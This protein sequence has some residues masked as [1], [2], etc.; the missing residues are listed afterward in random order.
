M[1]KKNYIWDLV[2]ISLYLFLNIAC[3]YLITNEIVIPKLFIF[4]KESFMVFNSI[5]GELSYLLMLLG[6]AYILFKTRR[7]RFIFLTIVSFVYSLFAFAMSV[8]VNYYG[9]LFSFG[10]LENFGSE[11]ASKSM[12]FLLESIPTVI[13]GSVPGFFISFLI[14]ILFYIIYRVKCFKK[15]K[16][17]VSKKRKTLLGTIIILC[18]LLLVITS[19][20]MYSSK[21][22]G[23]WFEYNSSP[24]YSS[25]AKGLINTY[26]D[27]G[28]KELFNNDKQLSL[29]DENKALN[30]LQNYQ[31]SNRINFYDNKSY[32][33]NLEFSGIF[34]DKNLLLIQMES[35]S[36]F[37]IGLK[38]NVDGTFREVTPN[39]NQMVRENIYFSSYYTT[40][41]IG[42][43]SDSEFSILTGMY[44]I[45]DVFSIFSCKSDY[46]QTLPR[47]FK[48][49]GYDTF[50]SHANSRSFYDRGENH[51][52]MY[53]FDKFYG[54]EDLDIDEDEM[55]RKWLS[56]EAF[57]KQ[58]I[59]ILA[60]SSNNS[61]AFA[62]TVSNHTPFSMPENGTMD[63]W[64]KN[65]D[66]LLNSNVSLS[67]SEKTN[68]YYRG[69]LEYA[70]YT[71]YAIGKA[72]EYLKEKE[73]YDDTIVVLYGDHGVD[74]DIF[75][76]F[77]NY[78]DIFQSEFFPLF[79]LEKG[80]QKKLNEYK[81]IC[82][83]PFIITGK[84][85]PYYRSSRTL[86]NVDVQRTIANL[87]DL[88]P[89][90]YFGVDA[91]SEEP[92]VV[93]SSKSNT[94]FC[95][96]FVINANSR[97]YYEI[98]PSSYSKSYGNKVI[99]RYRYLKDLFNKTI[100]YDLM[101][102]LNS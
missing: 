75:E 36:N 38:V 53:G 97:D 92:N 62:I 95:D 54:S 29:K 7:G 33:N 35:I 84:D 52:K 32:G 50:S 42:N 3:L 13:R 58:T 4:E 90:Y 98:N 71:D 22:K 63:K 24:L 86:A 5:I 28:L 20:V 89:K 78:S 93:Y 9:M 44:P 73:L 46:Y 39:L 87:F 18:G 83:V 99:N 101:K 1:N 66:N 19:S 31:N 59:D 12:E 45:G 61:F 60:S 55:I 40:T 8:F 21:I 51:T 74:T 47:L 64:F 43:T 102:K 79:Q 72:I 96:D 69:Y 11:G 49:Y 56:D 70:C 16:L 34:K 57:L 85:V 26:V 94:I 27:L 76:M 25:E 10:C 65:K 14:I 17:I 6:I 15:D 41:G 48:D 30:E 2:F 88:N 68:D 80:R 23:T 91:F 82:N 100:R 67:K 37:L 77:Y 81:F